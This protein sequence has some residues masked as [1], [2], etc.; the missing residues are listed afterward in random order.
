MTMPN[1]VI[2]ID[3]EA[4]IRM[5]ASQTLELADISVACFENAEAALQKLPADFPGVVVCDIKMPR[6]NGL[7]FLEKALSLDRDLP[8]ILVTGHGDIA[9]AVGAMRE[10]AYDFLE[11]P[12]SPDTLTEVVRRALDKRRLTL[13]NR[14][15]RQEL[16]AQSV[17]GPRI[18]GR[19]PAMQRLRLLIRQVA[20]TAADVLILGETGTGKELV[21]RSL[22][23]YSRRRNGNF[24]AVNC[25]AVPEQLI[26]SE[27][28]GH[29]AGAFTGA[30][31]KR[32]GKLE[33]SSGGTLFLDEIESMPLPLQVRMLRSLQ[34]R[35]VERLGSNQPIAIDLRVVAATKVDLREAADQGEFRE[36][37]Y[38]RLNVVTLDIPPLRER[39]EDIPLLF[40][41]FALVASARYEKEIPA[42]STQQVP[43]LLAHTWP[44]NVRELRNLAERYVLL[45]ENCGYDLERLM[46][47][48]G[49]V[50]AM[51]LKE[52]VEQFEKSLIEQALNRC[53][54]NISEA[55]E[56][57][58]IPRKTLHDKVRKYGLDRRQF[59][60]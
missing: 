19:T 20:D 32:I 44:G 21:A 58:G 53:R 45:G 33:H 24:V 35:N 15:L 17:P 38:Y 28:F 52:Q 5:A 41:H 9:M 12:Y 25:G 39:R 59:R 7:A 56:A 49:N 11:K 8:I 43:I 1:Q 23:E 31:S 29:E 50:G 46:P 26:E 30:R 2:F 55:T 42:L 37:L 40:Q 34:E 14:T 27:L 36:D 10:G 22:H 16:E 51:N 6:M 54:G 3:D 13:E 4:H 60:T 47:G 18:I 48:A 57:L